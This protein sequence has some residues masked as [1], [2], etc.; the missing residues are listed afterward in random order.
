MIRFSK[1]LCVCAMDHGKEGELSR[2]HRLI[3]NTIKKMSILLV[4]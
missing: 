2:A 1:L 4:T 3:Y